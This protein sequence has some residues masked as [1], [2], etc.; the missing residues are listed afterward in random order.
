MRPKPRDHDEAKKKVLQS[1]GNRDRPILIGEVSV[2]LGA[3]SLTE[4]EDLLKDMVDDGSLREITPKEARRFS[5][6]HGYLRCK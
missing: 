5:R 4:T 1:A 2:M 3:W 6:T